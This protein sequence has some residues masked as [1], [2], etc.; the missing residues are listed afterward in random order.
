[1][2]PR[3]A[4]DAGASE[5]GDLAARPGEE[6]PV[7]GEPLDAG[8]LVAEADDGALLVALVLL[9]GSGVRLGVSLG[10]GEPVAPVAE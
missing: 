6:A 9:G 7:E 4:T 2:S 3:S 1:M 5:L 8:A 10:E